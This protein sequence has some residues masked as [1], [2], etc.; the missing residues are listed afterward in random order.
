MEDLVL[1]AQDVRKLLAGASGDAALLWLYGKT[2]GDPASAEQA[3]RMPAH[4]VEIAAAALRQLG[5]WQ[6]APAPSHVLPSEPPHYGEQDVLAALQDPSFELLRGEAQR[7]MGRIL[8]TEELKILLGMRGYLGLPDEVISLLLT[9]CLERNRARGNVR[10]PSLRQIERVA[11]RWADAGI[12]TLEAASAHMQI[13]LEKTSRIG[14]I[15]RLMQISD[16]R[17]TAPEEKYVLT[18]IDWGFPDE[19]IAMAYERCCLSTGRLNWAYM[20]SILK[21]WHGQ[22]LHTPDEIR[23]GDVPA[24]RRNGKVTPPDAG[25]LSE[26]EKNAIARM[27]HG[28][29]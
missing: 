26:M 11:Y 19:A 4:R 25:N 18:W 23:A 16:R 3:L 12:D 9:Y 22:H 13:E 29:T 7:R 15:R 24:P 2:G 27:L 17:L 10:P 28:K 5:L 1:S 6:D 21:S 14:P 8:S 20:N